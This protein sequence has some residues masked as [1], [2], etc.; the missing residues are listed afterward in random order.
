[1]LSGNA[2]FQTAAPQISQL[3]DNL[4][5]TR[6]HLQQLWTSKKLKLEQCFQLRLFEQDAEKVGMCSSKIKSEMSFLIIVNSIHTDLVFSSKNV[7]VVCLFEFIVFLQ[8]L[9]N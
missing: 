4:Q 3:L 9:E 7:N 6:T 1:M 2:D 8:Y 5:A